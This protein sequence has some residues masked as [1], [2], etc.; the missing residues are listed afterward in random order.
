MSLG[1]LAKQLQ[2]LVAGALPLVTSKLQF[3][4]PFLNPQIADE[5]WPMTSIL[6][7]ISSGVTYNLAQRFQ[8]PTVARALCLWGLGIAAASF[9]ALT[10][11]VGNLFLS[12]SPEWQDFAVRTLFIILFVCVGLVVGWCSSRI[13]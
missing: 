7:I 12:E 3:V 1:E 11:L 6:S 10:A 13:L 8:K 2:A 5:M 9:V 4:L